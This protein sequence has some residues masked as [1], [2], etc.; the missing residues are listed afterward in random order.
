MKCF[1][2]VFL[3]YNWIFLNK[4]QNKKGVYSIS[5]AFSCL[6]A[7]HTPTLKIKGAFLKA[8]QGSNFYF[9]KPYKFYEAILHGSRLSGEKK[10]TLSQKQY[11]FIAAKFLE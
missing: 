11:I 3:R 10:K 9:K 2:P 8:K 6:K 4:Q 1:I 7:N 5:S